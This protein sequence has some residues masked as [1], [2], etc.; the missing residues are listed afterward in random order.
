MSDNRDDNVVDFPG[1]TTMPISPDKVLTS[2]V[3]K[4]DTVYLIGRTPEGEMYVACSDGDKYKML[5]Y[6]SAVK[7]MM[8]S[9]MFE[10]AD[11]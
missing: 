1:K 3:G 5:W 8:L 2:A 7:H 9:G 11:E 10:D 4:L 6:V